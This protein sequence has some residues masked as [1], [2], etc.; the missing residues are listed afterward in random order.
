MPLIGD[1]WGACD[2]AEP[3]NQRLRSSI[4]IEGA[5]RLLVDAGPDLRAQMLFNDISAFDA[6]LFTH[7]HADHIMGVDELRAVNRATG[8]PLPVFAMGATLDDLQRRFD[9]AFLPPVPHGF[10]R[11]C[12]VP[13]LVAAGTE[14]TLAGMPVRLFAQDHQ[15]METLGLRTGGFAYS[16]DVVRLPEASLAALAGIDT[17][18]VDCFQRGPHPVHAGLEAVLAWVERLQPR[19]TILTHMSQDM[20]WAWMAANLPTGIEAGFDGM[21]IEA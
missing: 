17:W 10:F 12:L 8:A 21:V 18:V 15:V 2:P 19:R 3:R 6:V 7:S 20:D 11:P 14:V 5:G 16:T 1:H 4:L 13:N 9:Y